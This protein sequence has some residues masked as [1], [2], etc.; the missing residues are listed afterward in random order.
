MLYKQRL[1]NFN[2]NEDINNVLSSVINDFKSELNDGDDFESLRIASRKD[3]L[4]EINNFVKF[5]RVK[6]KK[7]LVLGIG[8]S[9]LGSKTLI[10]VSKNKDVIFLENIDSEKVEDTFN[11]L[12]LRNTAVLTISKSGK[13]IECI[14]QTLLL[15]NIYKLK[16]GELSVKEHFFF[17]TETKESPLIKLSKHFDITTIEH[18]KNI[19]GRFSYL[20]N[21]GLIPAAFAGLDILKIR[22]GAYETINYFFEDEN[23]IKDIIYKQNILYKNG[24]VGNIL[25]TYHER[26][27]SLLEWYRQLWAESLGKNGFGTLPIP[28]VGTIDQHSQLQLYLGGKKN[29]FFTF[30]VK[31]DNNQVLKI[32]DSF[33]NDFEYLKNRTIDDIMTVE[34][35]STVEILKQKDLPIRIFEYEKLNEKLISQFMMQFI[36]ET[37]CVGKINNINPF[38]QPQVEE[39][40]QIAREIYKTWHS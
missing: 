8:G 26:L 4:E 25:M 11:S 22:Q 33:V 19:G 29:L 32:S 38:G 18:N 21:V 14:A 20:S 5:I 27:N 16:L 1:L 3:D 28:A 35:N 13:T 15:I 10:S 24:I 6:F 40:K 39:K 7:L 30:F 9:S 17:L 34:F 36:I 12:D 37:I 23:F 2:N 31:K